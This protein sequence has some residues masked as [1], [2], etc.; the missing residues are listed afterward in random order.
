M[1]R[2]DLIYDGRGRGIDPTAPVVTALTPSGAATLGV[3]GSRFASAFITSLETG[4]AA[5]APGVVV[6]RSPDGTRWS[7]VVGD[8]GVLD[9]VEL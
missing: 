2:D 3:T 6:L 8:D 5:G 1:P 9:A 7:L 4:T